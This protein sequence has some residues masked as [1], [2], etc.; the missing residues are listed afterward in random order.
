MGRPKKHPDYDRNG[1]VKE[2]IDEVMDYY[3]DDA[4][5]EKDHFIR[6][7]AR[8]F[9][10][11]S[12]KVQKMLI[13]AGLY[14]TDVSHEV[15]AFYEQGRSIEEI[16]KL[17]NM[18]KASVYSYLPYSNTILTNEKYAD[19]VLLKKKVTVDHILQRQLKNDFTTVNDYYIDNHHIPIVEKKQFER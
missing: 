18:R 12:L 8:R 1:I 14:E 7:V 19:D 2:M 3:L 17:M 15:Q 4:G 10:I 6:D 16:Q 5:L 13:T 9:G 11:T